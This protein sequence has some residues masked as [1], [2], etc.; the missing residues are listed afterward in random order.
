M[1]ITGTTLRQHRQTLGLSQAKLAEIADIPQH[2]LSAFELEKADLPMHVLN[3]VSNALANSE[4]VTAVVKKSEAL[5][6]SQVR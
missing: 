4:K 2:M 3:A 5:Q 6:R 1:K